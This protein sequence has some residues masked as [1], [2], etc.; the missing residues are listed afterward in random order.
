[1]TVLLTGDGC[2]PEEVHSYLYKPLK[3]RVTMKKAQVIHIPSIFFIL[4][5]P[6]L[7]SAIN[8]NF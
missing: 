4:K 3:V 6:M 1:M 5:H 7:W 2:G 8:K